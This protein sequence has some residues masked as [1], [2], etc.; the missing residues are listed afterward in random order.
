LD[1][2]NFLL[3][4]A[5]LSKSPPTFERRAQDEPPAR[6]RLSAAEL[7]R[8]AD[9]YARRLLA[10][11]PEDAARALVMATPEPLCVA[12]IAG[13][14]RA[15]LSVW[16][17][18]PS[19][20]AAELAALARRIG[21]HALLGPAAFAGL[22]RE[23][24]LRAAA[25]DAPPLRALALWRIGAGDEL[26][27]TS[28]GQVAPR[29]SGNVGA[30]RRRPADPRAPGAFSLAA[31]ARGFMDG[32]ALT[33]GDQLASLL[34]PASPA[35]LLTGVLAPLA[36]GADMTWQAPFSARSLAA[37]LAERGPVHLVAPA[38][39][40]PALGAAGL[41]GVDGI[42]TLT[43]VAPRGQGPPPF[44]HDLDPRRIFTLATGRGGAPTLTPW[45]R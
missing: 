45:R 28:P 36:S 39:A 24:R 13:A 44:A 25:T 34:T 41:L 22:E 15:G 12:A 3:R 29:R 8:I 16:L 14:Q 27:V 43:L 32:L 7:D 19:L 31:P 1:R 42:A 21:A 26:H 33:H 4:R 2:L 35:G 37:L 40:A 30:A 20:G 38:S 23:S 18:S 9:A 6:E 11:L 17:A 10:S 5:A